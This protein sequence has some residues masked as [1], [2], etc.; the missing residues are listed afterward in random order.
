MRSRHFSSCAS[1][2]RMLTCSA[3]IVQGTP[4]AQQSIKIGPE[5]LGLF[6]SSEILT[7]C[8]HFVPLHVF[9]LPQTHKHLDMIKT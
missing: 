1:P 4:S 3:Y 9:A 6:T 5:N 8:G 7:S 2:T